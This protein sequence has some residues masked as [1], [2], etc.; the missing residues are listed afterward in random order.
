MAYT[1][2]THQQAMKFYVLEGKSIAQISMLMKI[3]EKTLYKW[4]VKETW[5]NKIKSSGG[6]EIGIK[7]NEAFEN[8]IRKAIADN[9][10]GDPATAD[11][12][13]KLLIMAQKFTPKKLMLAN[14]F[15]MLEDITNY[16]KAKIGNDKFMEEWAKYL[17]EI[18][19]FLR[20]KYNE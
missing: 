16:I 3:P 18:S 20:K 17:P 7:F 14:I 10:L 19:D 4:K 12:L 15:N 1:K 13:Y 5:D 11:S 8:A 9:K 2:I 6:I